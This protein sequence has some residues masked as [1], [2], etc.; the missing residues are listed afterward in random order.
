M[1]LTLALTLAE[2]TM[3]MGGARRDATHD[4]TP[5]SKQARQESNRQPP[6]LEPAPSNAAVAPFVDFQRLSF[7]PPTPALLDNAGVGTIPGTER[8]SLLPPVEFAQRYT[9]RR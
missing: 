8:A 2:P 6:V 5:G 1:R 7:G 9:S 3:A 4:D